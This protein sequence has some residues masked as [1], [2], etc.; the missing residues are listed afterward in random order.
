MKRVPADLAA[1]EIVGA[2][3]YQTADDPNRAIQGR[4]WYTGCTRTQGDVVGE[5]E[6]GVDT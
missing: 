1:E 3:A 5:Y 6:P 2:V 4:T